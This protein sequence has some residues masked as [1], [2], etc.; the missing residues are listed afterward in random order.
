MAKRSEPRDKVCVGVIVGVHGVK[1]AV[2]VRSYTEDPLSLAAYGP[3]TDEGGKRFEVTVMGRAKDALIVGVKG[4]NDRDQAL[5]LKGTRLYV[6]RSA[7]PEP[8]A[9]SFYYADLVGLSVELADGTGIGRVAAVYNFGASDVIEVTREGAPPIDV[10]FTRRAV[11]VVDVKGG[12]IVI[13][14][15]EGLLEEGSPEGEPQA[16]SEAGRNEAGRKRGASAGAGRRVG[17]SAKARGR[18]RSRGG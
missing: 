9:D 3:L 12:R 6:S 14:P 13:D 1:G 5:A 8:E 17:K 4:L 18:G 15:P 16:A 2:R 10:P 11:P 7:L